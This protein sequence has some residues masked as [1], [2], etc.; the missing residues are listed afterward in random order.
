[1]KIASEFQT[2]VQNESI[3]GVDF[4]KLEPNL[5]TIKPIIRDLRKLYKKNPNW[6]EVPKF[7]IKAY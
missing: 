1:M 5:N 2:K 4:R 6:F 7:A 3:G